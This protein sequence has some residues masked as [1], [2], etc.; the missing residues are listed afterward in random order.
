MNPRTAMKRA[1]GPVR[2]PRVHALTNVRIVWADAADFLRD[3]VPD[4]SVDGFLAEHDLES[5]E[6]DSAL[7]TIGGGN[8]FAEL[9]AVETLHEKKRGIHEVLTPHAPRRFPGNRAWGHFMGH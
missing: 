4:E 2:T 6:F 1:Q 9:Q 7:G 5:T 3:H 8:H